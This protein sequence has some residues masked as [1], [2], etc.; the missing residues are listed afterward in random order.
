M[1]QAGEHRIPALMFHRRHVYEHNGGIVDQKYLDDD[2]GD[3]TV[4]LK[5]DIHET[6]QDAYSLLGSLGKMAHNIH[7]TF[8]ELFPPLH[9]PIN[10]FEDK[11]VRKALISVDWVSPYVHPSAACLSL[12]TGVLE[13]LLTPL[14]V[15]PH[16]GCVSSDERWRP[17]E[18][19]IPL[20]GVF[21]AIASQE[22]AR[23]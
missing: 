21:G 9:G 3:T 12:C 11:K 1:E 2:S 23:Q 4:C 22:P 19:S 6:Q 8:H 13:R 10:A 16:R 5:Q 20:Q 7:G 18:R 15:T 14:R 17:V